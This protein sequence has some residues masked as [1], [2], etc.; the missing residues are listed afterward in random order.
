MMIDK[1]T[2][3]KIDLGLEVECN[4]R[5]KKEIQEILTYYGDEY[6]DDFCNALLKAIKA[7]DLNTQELEDEFELEVMS[8]KYD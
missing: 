4:N 7:V 1:K 5:V 2:M 8:G 6:G 3:A